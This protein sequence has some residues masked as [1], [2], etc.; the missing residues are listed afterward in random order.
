M[1]QDCP[2]ESIYN[3]IPRECT[4]KEKVTRHKSKF[5]RN[6]QD[7]AVKNKDACRTMGPAKVA[8]RPPDCFLRKHEKE[9]KMPPETDV[10]HDCAREFHYPDK[11]HRKPP[12]PRPEE[13]PVMGLRTNKNFITENAVETIMS[14]PRKP[15]KVYVDT[16]RGDKHCLIPSGLEPV[17]IHK[18]DFGETPEYVKKRKDEM[19]RAQDEYDAYVTEHFRRGAMRQLTSE[20]RQAL[21]DGLKDN[22]EQLHREFLQLSVV[23]DT[24]PKKYR[25]ERLEADMKQLERDVELLDTHPVIY[26][27]N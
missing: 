18:K 2:D 26:I 22:W 7:D 17:Y 23:I 5:R 24:V 15:Q 27:A 25:K 21:I 13:K 11:D 12:V 14:V 19:K 1:Y 8:T 3:L 4:E 9:P 20:E 10:T 6:V 16:R